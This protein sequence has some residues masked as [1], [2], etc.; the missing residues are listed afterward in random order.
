LGP[1]V[2]GD[3][4]GD[5]RLEFATVGD[6]VNVASRL[7]QMTCEL[8]AEIVVSGALVAAVETIAQPEAEHLLDGFVRYPQ[9]PVRGRNAELEMFVL[10][11]QALPDPECWNYSAFR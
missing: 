8:G 6:T 3:M 7:E 4:G 11:R 1:A 2:L 5:N 9:R 10:R